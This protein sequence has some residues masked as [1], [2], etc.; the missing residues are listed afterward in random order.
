MTL[1]TNYVLHFMCKENTETIMK[2]E[3]MWFLNT[4][5]NYI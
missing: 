3:Y 2:G 1:I 4:L 5:S